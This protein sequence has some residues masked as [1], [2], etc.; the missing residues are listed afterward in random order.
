LVQLPDHQ[1][2]HLHLLNLPSQKI[3]DLILLNEHLQLNEKLNEY[4]LSF[5]DIDKLLNLLS[6]VKKYGFDGKKIVGKLKRIQ[7][8]QNKEERLKHHCEVL[9]NQVKECNKVLPLAQ[10]IIAMNIDI[11]ELL[12]FD[13]TVNQLAKQYDLP[14]SVASK[15]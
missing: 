11:S 12:V 14:A 9:S 7:R 5:Q 1:T 2:D 4:N 6:N 3:V 15:G 10:K 8:L 13:A